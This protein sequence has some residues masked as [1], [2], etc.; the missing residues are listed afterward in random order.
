M[1]LG[2]PKD[3]RLR[4]FLSSALPL[5]IAAP[6]AESLRGRAL[7][8]REGL[9]A[10]RT[11]GSASQPKLLLPPGVPFI[12]RALRR[13]QHH[14][15]RACWDSLARRIGIAPALALDGDRGLRRDMRRD[16]VK[17]AHDRRDLRRDLDRA[18]YAAARHERREPHREYRDLNHDRRELDWDRR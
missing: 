14:K 12:C 3:W 11:A 10:L 16:E 5:S 7:A 1:G 8:A 18:N 2:E 17:I 4:P 13:R 9:P 6:I 15:T